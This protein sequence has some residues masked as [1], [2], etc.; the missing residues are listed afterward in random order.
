MT[1]L[2]LFTT[3]PFLNS[4]SSSAGLDQS[5]QVLSNFA[6]LLTTL[7][8]SRKPPRSKSS[9]FRSPFHLPL[10]HCY[11]HL[12][13]RWKTEAC[14]CDLNHHFAYGH[15]VRWTY[16]FISTE[17]KAYSLPVR[18]RYQLSSSGEISR[19]GLGADNTGTAPLT[20]TLVTFS[21]FYS[22]EASIGGLGQDVFAEHH[23]G[24]RQLRPSERSDHQGAERG[25]H[26][27]EGG[28]GGG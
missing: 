7:S 23:W 11:L 26:P 5:D 12:S 28:G 20:V 9:C 10:A 22:V 21:E 18:L 1:H 19:A 15:L 25:K 14:L 27:E 2:F 13:S 24:D 4:Y 8:S 17:M 3:L 6:H 16:L